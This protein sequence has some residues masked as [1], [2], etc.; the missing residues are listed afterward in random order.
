MSNILGVFLNRALV[1]RKVD[2]EGN[3][4]I[5]H[6]VL[7][8]NISQYKQIALESRCACYSYYL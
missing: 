8:V 4:A 7:S 1:N 3:I 2:K 6:K 5:I